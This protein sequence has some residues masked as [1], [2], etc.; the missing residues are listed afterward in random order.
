MTARLCARRSNGAGSANGPA[1][2]PLEAWQRLHD[3][4][5]ASVRSAVERAF[6]TMKR[7]CGMSRVHYP[8]LARNAC[9]LQL[10]VAM[11]MK[12]EAGLALMSAA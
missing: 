2:Y 11:A 9:H 7:W 6:D 4:W 5:A 1:P 12:H 10:F 8:G 3:A